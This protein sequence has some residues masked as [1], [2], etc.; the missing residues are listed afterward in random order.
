MNDLNHT[1][2]SLRELA[3]AYRRREQ[4]NG[5]SNPD[6]PYLRAQAKAFAAA[7]D[8]IQSTIDNHREHH[9]LLAEE[10]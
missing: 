4:A 10:G 1:I 6:N 9:A 7:A 5:V 8:A 3:D 2:R